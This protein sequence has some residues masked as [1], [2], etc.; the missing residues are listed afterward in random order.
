MAVTR[1]RKG[2]ISYCDLCQHFRRFRTTATFFR[3]VVVAVEERR[4]RVRNGGGSGVR[5][6]CMGTCATRRAKR[7]SV[8][9]RATMHRL[10]VTTSPAG[11]PRSVPRRGSGRCLV[12]D[13][14]LKGRACGLPLAVSSLPLGLLLPP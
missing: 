8:D 5:V 6:S 12:M 7:H 9:K 4:R 11:V 3:M 14:P 2:A 13:P 1:N 10:S